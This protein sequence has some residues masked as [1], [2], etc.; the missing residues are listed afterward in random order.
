MRRA[1][2]VGLL[3]LLVPAAAHAAPTIRASIAPTT[4]HVGDPFRYTVVARVP[5]RA[6]ANVRVV[7]DSG[8]FVQIAGPAVSR[9]SD[10]GATVVTV[11]ETLV[12]LDLGCVSGATARH[13]V[14]PAPQV[15]TGSTRF[16]GPRTTVTVTPR[17][18]AHA[19]AAGRAAYLRDT[20]APTLTPRLRLAVAAVIAIALALALSGAAVAFVLAEVRRRKTLELNVR[21]S[22]FDLG[23]ALRLL[24]ESAKRP[25]PDRRRAA[26]LVARLASP[27]VVDEATRVAWARPAPGPGDVE[28]LAAD[29]E[30][31]S[32]THR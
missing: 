28:S 2:V 22:P 24:R 14:L 32:G 9:T 5:G 4:V 7:A 17:V 23:I 25:E 31:T 12:C 15:F 26:D 16:G 30:R 29:V 13:V 11:T 20:S 3:A 19:V 8:A 6:G 18:T 21:R 27:E 1:L 10:S